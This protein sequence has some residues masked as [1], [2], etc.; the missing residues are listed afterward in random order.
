M[1]RVEFR[2]ELKLHKAARSYQTCISRDIPHQPYLQGSL[3]TRILSIRQALRN[4][5][6]LPETDWRQ[7]IND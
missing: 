1:K 4:K 3:L 6:L 2:I 5:A 7:I